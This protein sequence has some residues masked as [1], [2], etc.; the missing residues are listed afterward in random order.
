MASKNNREHLL[1]EMVKPKKYFYVL[2]PILAM[3]W[4]EQDRGI[5]PM[6]FETLVD[7]LVDDERLLGDIRQLLKNKRAGFEAEYLPRIDSIS[8]FINTKLQRLVDKA[9]KV[10]RG[11]AGVKSMND[12]FLSVLENEP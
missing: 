8:L 6:E 9:K 5:V 12:F 11:E 10:E 3:Q 4:I 7:A 1:G 2:R